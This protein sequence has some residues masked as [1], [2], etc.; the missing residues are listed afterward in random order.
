MTFEPLITVIVCTYN[1]C[2][3]LTHTLDALIRQEAYYPFDIIVVDNNSHDATKDVVEEIGK[4]AQMPIMYYVEQQQGIAYARNRGANEAKGKYIAYIDDDAIPDKDWLTQIVWAFTTLKPSPVCV[5]GRVELTWENGRSRRFPAEYETIVGKYDFGNESCY[6]GED[7]YLIT[8]NAA[9]HKELFLRTGGFRTYLGR[10]GDCLLS[11]EDNDMY[12]RLYK[13]GVKIYYNPKQIIYHFV[14]R[15]RQRLTWLA[16]R[17]FWDGVTQVY[18][19]FGNEHG[20][21]IPLFRKALYDMKCSLCYC[22]KGLLYLLLKRGQASV[23]FLESIRKLGRAITE[24][25][26]LIVWRHT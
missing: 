16:K 4:A 15:S 11:G 24:I 26:L 23:N 14:P 17:I 22:G 9:F 3:S 5:V 25:R 20:H 18:L 6:L 2:A 21:S 7:D 8:M 10:K 12:H 19:D 1:R 13:S